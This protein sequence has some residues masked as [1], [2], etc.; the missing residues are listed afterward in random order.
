MRQL[1]T[2]GC[3]LEHDGK[4]LILHRHPNKSQGNT[5]GLPAGKVEPGESDPDAI[6]REVREETGYQASIEQ[7]EFL[8]D[9]QF[10]FSN[11]ELT[12]PTFRIKLQR[13][14][15][16]KHSAYEHQ[17]FRWVTAEECYAMPDLIHG[18][19]DLLERLGYIKVSA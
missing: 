3:F 16:V 5:W 1:R 12:F 6:L 14:F 8:G 4:F 11:L 9:Q 10:H 18:L 2:V 17:A 19:H 7:L 15:Q 13:P